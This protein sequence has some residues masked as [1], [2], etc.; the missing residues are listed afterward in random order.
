M[1][2]ISTKQ[3]GVIDYLFAGSVYALSRRLPASETLRRFLAASALGVIGMSA[4]TSYELGA[5]KVLP[6][7]A[8]VALDLVLGSAFTAAPLLFRD[9]DATGKATLAGL[10]ITGTAVALLTQTDG[11]PQ[12]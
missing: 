10:G 6:M 11:S 5:L 2:P 4:L 7:K 12:A 9:E 1:K 3:H 8:H